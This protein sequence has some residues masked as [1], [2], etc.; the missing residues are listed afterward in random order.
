MAVNEV[1]AGP[2]DYDIA[3]PAYTVSGSAVALG[4]L[5]GVAQTNRRADGN[6]SVRT[7]G[8]HNFP[9]ADAVAA[10]GVDMYIIV[11]TGVI[12]TTV[13][14]NVYFGVSLSAKKTDGTVDI[15]IHQV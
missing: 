1:F 5:V 6:A 14:A 11:A 15:K 8:V 2:G 4:K 9:C 12:T 10:G 3:V 13:G 7:Y